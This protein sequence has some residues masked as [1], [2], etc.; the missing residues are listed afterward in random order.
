M[1]IAL[2]VLTMIGSLSS[3][4]QSIKKIDLGTYGKM[5][6][7]EHK[8]FAEEVKK[9]FKQVQ[10]RDSVHQLFIVQY[11]ASTGV[12]MRLVSF[13]GDS[14]RI[15]QDSIFLKLRVPKKRK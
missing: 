8:A 15:T 9:I 3:Y 11:V 4:A 10:A 13:S 7:A 1:K 6:V 2:L 14:L 5:K 12:D